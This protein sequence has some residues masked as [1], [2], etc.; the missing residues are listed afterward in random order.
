MPAKV[1]QQQS[2]ISGASGTADTYSSQLRAME[3]PLVDE[4]SSGG[5][6]FQK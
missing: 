5:T 6:L 3:A 4:L 1:M 2:V